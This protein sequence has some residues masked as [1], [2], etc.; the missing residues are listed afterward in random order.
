LT[1]GGEAG[2]APVDL[3]VTDFV[4]VWARRLP[5][6]A[7]IVHE[8]RPLSYGAL[9]HRIA[10]ARAFFVRHGLI[11][12]GVVVVAVA[13]LQTFWSLSLA[14]RSLGVTTIQPRPG[15]PLE[16]LGLPEVLGVVGSPAERSLDLDQACATAGLPLL[17]AAIE[18]ETPLWPTRAAS[19][20]KTGG[21]ILLTS[22]TT[23]LQKK[24][25]M[26]PS[27]E[28]AYIRYRR[29]VMDISHDSV[30]V[31][32]D[33]AAWT[34]AGYKGVVSSLTAGATVVIDQRP[35]SHAPLLYHGVTY[36]VILPSM[37]H[38]LLAGPPDALPR[39]PALQIQVAA[40]ALTLREIEA[41]KARIT[42]DLINSFGSTEV[43]PIAFTPM[44][45]AEDQRWH[46]LVPDRGVQVVDDLDRPAPA[47]QVGRLRV[48]TTDGPTGYLS[49][50]TAT[51]AFFKD[52]YFYP[53]D[54]AEI[55]ADGRMALHGRVTD[56]I[57]IK[58]Q[59]IL[60]A[61]IE[62]R[63]RDVLAVSGVCLFSMQNQAGEEEIHVVLE[64]PSPISPA[65][66]QEVLLR[67]L[68]GFPG[69]HVHFVPALPRNALGKV[70]RL[71]ARDQALAAARARA[72]LAAAPP[73]H[74]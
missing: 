6:K 73:P 33:F 42:P 64:T 70:L 1:V 19:A 24:I 35:I 54:L 20:G 16:D 52:G 30:G 60:P 51:R 2:P 31:L 69:A 32:F 4:F 43:R 40:G 48:P 63:L 10:Q 74:V 38:E 56:V 65:Q 59:K 8:G 7:A 53:G 50:E 17:Y 28:P 14:L 39:N 11:G 71:A 34:G 25:L 27:F 29:R 45:I 67:E 23:G 5:D 68:T 49:D 12:P 3:Q 15:Q 66:L 36:A 18:A 46:R 58:G 9:A 26:E 72:Q 55:R 21:H 61:P 47:G 41:L 44:E 57:N 37:V 22:G 62:E 13:N